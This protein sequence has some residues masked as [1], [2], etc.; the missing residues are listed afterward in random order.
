MSRAAASDTQEIY[1][2]CMKGGA[3]VKTVDSKQSSTR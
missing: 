1:H 2:T 3:V